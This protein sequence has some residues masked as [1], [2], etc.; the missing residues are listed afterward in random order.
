MWTGWVGNDGKNGGPVLDNAEAGYDWST[1]PELLVKAGISWKVY[2]DA[3]A[4]LTAAQYWGW[5]PDAYIGNYGDNSLLYFHQYQN[6]MPGSPLYQGALQGTNIS[7]SGTL[8]DQFRA[9]IAAGTLPQVSWIVAPEAFTEHPNWPAN[10]GAWYVSQFLDALTENPEI[11]SKTVF[12]LMYDENDGFFDHMVPPTPPVSRANGLST[13]DTTNEV[14]AGNS[15]FE[16][17]PVGLGVRVPMIVISPWSKGG[18]VNS[19]VFDHTSLIRFIEA[20]FGIHEHNITAWRRAVCGDLTSTLDFRT[21]NDEVVPLPPTSAYVP[22]DNIRHPDYVPTLPAAQSVPKQ[23]KG[24]RPARALPYE[25]HVEGEA[26]LSEGALEI[27]FHNTGSAAAVFQVRTSLTQD[28]PW[29][30]T[31]A[32]GSH[33]FDTWTV[34]NNGETAYGLSVYGPNGF[35]RSFQGTDVANLSVRSTYHENPDRPG[36][37]LEIRNRG[38]STEKVHVR[39]AYSKNVVTESVEPGRSMVWHFSLEETYGW[40]DLTIAVESDTTLRRQLAGHVETGSDSTS[41]PALG[42]W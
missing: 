29:T 33:L 26:D 39:D 12:F 24:L 3:G 37:T 6:S 5:G 17:G 21:P 22:P 16:A 40:Y 20:R 14:F 30:Y 18:Y 38:S 1:Y 35:F 23:E 15:S 42:G 2:Q 41:D 7:A 34:T 36:I 10:Y 27:R 9:D 11:W 13:V 32:P 4:G 8:L 28:G 25:V 19:Q 31:V